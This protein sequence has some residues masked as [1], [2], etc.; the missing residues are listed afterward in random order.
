MHVCST[1]SRKSLPATSTC[2]FLSIATSALTPPPAPPSTDIDLTTGWTYFSEA[3]TWTDADE[4]CRSGGG[5][6]V[7]ILSAAQNAA[8]GGWLVQELGVPSDTRVWLGGHDL[9]T[10]VR[11]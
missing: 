4:I 7:S 8:F 9:D 6:L 3:A 11:E 10:E 1:V 5:A 2:L